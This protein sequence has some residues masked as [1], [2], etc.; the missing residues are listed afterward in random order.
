MPVITICSLKGGTGKSTIALSLGSALSTRER[1]VLVIDCDPQGTV[2]EWQ[3]TRKQ[4][5][6]TIMVQAIAGLHEQIH[7][8]GPVYGFSVIV[9]TPPASAE[10]T[11]SAVMAADKLILPVTPGMPDVW[12]TEKLLEIYQE[13]KRYKPTLEARLLINKV[14]R[15][16]KLGRTF[17]AFLVDRFGLDVTN[18]FDLDVFK[19]EITS[20]IVFSKAYIQGL[21]IDN[22][23]PRSKGAAE[24]KRLT[25][26]VLSWRRE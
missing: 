7:K 17:R 21:T 19:T 1:K 25:K 10:A 26:E 3:K 15:R 24:F 13:A 4:E 23:Q 20:S 12:S 16:T 5:E 8:T 2:S 14:D 18:N 9:D 11:R 6:P 22:Y